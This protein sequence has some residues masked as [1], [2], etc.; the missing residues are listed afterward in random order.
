MDTVAR[1]DVDAVD[2]SLPVS[3]AGTRHIKIYSRV[4][5]Y[6]NAHVGYVTCTLVVNVCIYYVY[7][8]KTVLCALHK[9]GSAELYDIESPTIVRWQI[10]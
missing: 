4:Y 5:S 7:A 2:I 3:D 1:H 8:K 6:P 10:K 9:R